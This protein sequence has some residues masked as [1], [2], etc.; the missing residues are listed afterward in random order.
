MDLKKFTITVL[1][2]VFFILISLNCSLIYS[3]ESLASGK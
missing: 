1:G 2:L 3:A